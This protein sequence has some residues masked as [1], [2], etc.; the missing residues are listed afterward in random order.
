MDGEPV[1]ATHHG[2]G[3]LV[4]TDEH[5]LVLQVSPCDGH[6]QKLQPELEALK[7]RLQAIRAAELLRPLRRE[8]APDIDVVYVDEDPL[9]LTRR[10]DKPRGRGRS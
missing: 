10:L 3:C 4:N 6:R 8:P 1:S 2:C 5:G 9:P 7:V